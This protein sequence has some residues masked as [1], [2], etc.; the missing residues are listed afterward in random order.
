MDCSRRQFLASMVGF[1]VVNAAN[2]S[3]LDKLLS[4]LSKANPK[5]FPNEY[6]PLSIDSLLDGSGGK[7]SHSR[8]NA[9]ILFL[10]FD[11]GPLPCTSK[12]LETLA[13]TRH[14]ATFFVVGR[15]LTNPPLREIAL[16]ALQQ[17]H[18]IGNHSY[19]HPDFS[20]ISAKRAEREISET[21]RLILDLHADVGIDS[22]SRKLFF[23]FPYGVPGSSSNFKACKN[24]LADLN[25]SIANWDLDTND[26]QIE[27]AGSR[28]GQ[29]RPVNVIARARTHDVILLHD[30]NHTAR[31][32][33]KILTTLDR[34][35]FL[36]VPLLWYP[37]EKI[38][39][40]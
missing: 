5:S 2:P 1:S 24:I 18:D 25:Y 32:L 16:K 22:T 30:R 9:Q 28:F 29:S 15:N 35:S 4:L 19:G 21:H 36:S 8:E 38:H 27:F 11:D 13:S 34:N 14:R 6:E 20:T 33:P 17:G 31:L 12:I 26:W 23:R 3:P 40:V 37:T 10:T 7:S 39:H